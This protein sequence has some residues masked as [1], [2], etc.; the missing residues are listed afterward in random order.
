MRPQTLY[1]RLRALVRAFILPALAAAVLVPA[2][3]RPAQAQQ[4]V[5]GFERDRWK[6]ALGLIKD[7]IKKN[8]YD[9][10]FHGI[11]LDAHFKKAEEKMK[12]AQSLGQLFGI[13]AQA[14]LDFD[15]SHLFF[16][17]PGR[18][19]RFDYGWRTQM[20]G[21]RCFVTA[22]KPG[23]DA[24]AKGLKPG[25]EI[26]GLDGYRM[27]RGNHWKMQ[28]AYYSLRPVPGVRFV[29][30]GPDGKE[31]QL[32]VM[33]KITQRKRVL[34][35]TGGDLNAFIRDM[36]DD[37]RDRRTASRGMSL[38]DSELMLWKFEEFAHTEDEIDGM[39][40]KA[41]KHKAL[42]IDLRGN[43]GGSEKTLL[44]ML[45]NLFDRDVN[46]GEVK[47]RKETK[48]LTAKTRG[49]DNVYKGDL[50]VLVDGD[51]GSASELFARVIQLEKRGTVVGDRTA[52]AVMRSRHYPH[53]SGMD[54]VAP[55]GVSVTDAD[56][57]MTDG[58]S[59]EHVGVT[60]DKVLLPTG[61]DLAAGRDPVLSQA[62]ALLG[63]KLDAEKAGALFPMKWK[64]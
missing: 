37:E 18:A 44:R 2:A 13:I 25:D 64:K 30:A 10:T 9:P 51:S 3:P 34:D 20:I 53:A 55:Y 39:M 41:R 32:D 45:S 59:L 42:V 27:T 58:Q 8:Y 12:Q 38:G 14:L 6:A 40:S 15:D 7:D 43:G 56:I 24:E 11:D 23:S 36:E 57:V 49:A 63:F 19:S 50:V 35:L 52:G 33:T 47:R 54:V 48:M 60:P 17:P 26:V 22:V 4:Q 61:A 62:I 1:P 28:Y 31:R 21:D 16:L 5:D 29:V 46:V